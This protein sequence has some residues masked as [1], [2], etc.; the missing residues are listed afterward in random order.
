[1]TPEDI[2]TRFRTHLENLDRSPRTVRLRLDDLAAF[3]AWF[4]QSTGRAFD[5]VA[6]TPPDVRDYRAY[7][8]SVRGLKPNSVNRALSSLSVFFSWARDEGLVASNPCKGVRPVEQ[9]PRPPRWLDRREQAALRR[10][11]REVVQLA[12]LKARLAGKTLP[13]LV[14]ARRDQALFAL[15]L[16]AGLRVGEVCNLRLSDVVLNDRSGHL[17]VRSGKRGK[18]REVPLNRSAR[19]ALR[20]WLEVRPE[21]EDDHLLLGRDRR[22]LQP[23]SVQR[24]VAYYARRAGL[25][26]VTPHV[27]RHTFAKNLVDAG[28][29]LTEVAALLGHAR[30]NTTAVYT[31]PGRGDLH[32][33]VE[34]VDW[35]EA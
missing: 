24:R 28:R 18:Y 35:G 19:Q 7:L 12:E 16:D 17:V 27:L 10:A 25:E 13:A 32:R 5:P 4:E 1:M 29:P 9:Q 14:R 2:L 34:A 20:A 23:R 31:Q 21:V 6:V 33:A 26:G 22:P 8:Q 11:L 3:V 15:M 30:L